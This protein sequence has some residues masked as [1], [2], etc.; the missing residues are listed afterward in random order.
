MQRL[1]KRTSV[2]SR[3]ALTILWVV[4]SGS[5]DVEPKLGNLR[6]ASL[7]GTRLKMGVNWFAMAVLLH[8]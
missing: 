5:L 1:L 6:Q 7:A 2:P 3:T 4:T 8:V